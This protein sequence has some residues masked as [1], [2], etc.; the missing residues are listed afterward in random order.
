MRR[1][2]VLLSVLAIMLC[3]L[4]I[5][6]RNGDATGKELGDFT[7]SW[8][9]TATTDDGRIIRSLTAFTAD[10]VAITSGLP[11]QPAPPGTGS[12]LVYMST[13]IG[14]WEHSTQ[15]S[16]IVTFVHIR[17]S[18]EGQPLGTVTVRLSLQGGEDP[19]H[20]IGDG[21]ATVADVDGNTIAE[22]VTA[23]QGS[24]IYAQAPVIPAVLPETPTEATPAS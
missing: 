19:D 15:Y 8:R 24:R 10:G 17:A 20:F 22:F 5:A 1:L 23:V 13:A 3:G 21:V 9:V 6:T 16:A 14:V 2:P 7:G 18:G 12:D 11:V 4:T